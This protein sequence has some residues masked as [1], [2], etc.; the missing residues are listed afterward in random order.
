M[1]MLPLNDTAYDHNQMIFYVSKVFKLGD[2]LA[3]AVVP[4]TVV[5]AV[6]AECSACIR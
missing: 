5:S 6:I 4:T 1:K 3:G 2:R